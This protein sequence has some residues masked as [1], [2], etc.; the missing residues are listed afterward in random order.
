[1]F[2][3][4]HHYVCHAPYLS[5]PEEYRTRF[6]EGR[7][8]A[9][10]PVGVPDAEKLG[11]VDVMDHRVAGR[12]KRRLQWRFFSMAHQLFWRGVDLGRRDH[13]D[14]ITALY[15]AG[16]AFSDF[17]FGAVRK[18]LED[19]GIYDDTI[20]I[21]LSD[22]GE[23]FYEHGG[24]E[25]RQLFKETLHVPLMIRFPSSAKIE[26]T[27]VRKTVRTVDLMP[28]LFDYLGLPIEIPVQGES[29]L[30]LVRGGGTYAPQIVSYDDRDFSRIRVVDDGWAYTNQRN[31][32]AS[33]WLFDVTKDP[34]E[35]NNLAGEQP[36]RMARMREVTSRRL[37]Q[38]AA[39]TERLREFTPS[40]PVLDPTLLEQ[41]KE[42]GY[43]ME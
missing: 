13:R 26:P 17:L 18:A 22:H 8:V 10:L 3:F 5:A 29:F 20:I 6:V 30:P 4:L 21:L 24:R 25:H 19:E 23:E 38:D 31:P 39:F 14:H 28:T 35:R 7:R 2:V 40:A 9:G 43:V 11:M 12:S 27:V 41:L 32:A 33:E 16:V 42:L 34:R 37:A 15:D 36:D 1:L